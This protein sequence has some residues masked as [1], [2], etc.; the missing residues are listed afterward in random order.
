[1][2]VSKIAVLG[3]GIA[4]T[5]T[6]IACQRNGLDVEVFERASRP[7]A[8]GAGVVLWPNAICILSHLG[9]V[10]AIERVGGRLNEMERVSSAGDQLN[11]ID[12]RKLDLHM[13]Y[14]SYS[15]LRKDLHNILLD[16]LERLGISVHY[17]FKVKE[18]TSVNG[19]P[20]VVQFDNGETLTA[21]II[22]GA[23]GRMN[24]MTRRFVSGDAQPKYQ[25]YVNW[26][27]LVE[28][29]SAVFPRNR[30]L[31]FWGTGERFGIVPISSQ[32]GYWA[33]CKAMP[34]GL[35]KPR[36]GNKTALLN[37]FEEWPEPIG[38]VIRTTHE[39]NIK[40]IEVY[41]HDPLPDRWHR[42]N[43]CLVGDAAHAALP[44]SGQ[45]AC[46]AI[47]DAWHFAECCKPLADFAGDGLDSAFAEFHALR[48]GKTTAI[49][50]NARHFAYSL[51][52]EDPE[53]CRQR[54]IKARNTND[55]LTVQGMSD[56]WGQGL[57]ATV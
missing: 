17:G 7:V 43:V 21:D 6:A 36:L 28:G 40:R 50:Q 44:T 18:V 52:S 41:D 34:V 39:A 55:E 56:F 3:A 15:I 57:P 2:T 1:M 20:A 23:D 9:L 33:G 45:G 14:P 10:P 38:D 5:C 51:F 8:N 27:G 25:G 4:G 47:E 46:Q 30:V 48:I 32:K 24:S 31:D 37:L 12:I 35:G 19:E 42:T 29:D 54:D 49:I 11:R 16:E 53:S 26:V 22:V 13:G